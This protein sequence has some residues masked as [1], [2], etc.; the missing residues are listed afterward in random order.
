V[1][2]SVRVRIP[3]GTPDYCMQENLNK[4]FNN[5]NT[6]DKVIKIPEDGTIYTEVELQQIVEEEKRNKEKNGNKINEAA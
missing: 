1:E 5:K 3:I 6:K 2:P 4:K